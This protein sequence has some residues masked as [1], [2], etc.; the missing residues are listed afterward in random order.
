MTLS[1]DQK[2]RLLSRMGYAGP[3]GE[4][5]MKNFLQTNPTAAKKFLAF[6]K[7]AAT[8]ATP[9][10]AM[11][12]SPMQMAE[13]GSV[14]SQD[15]YKRR[16]D[17][18]YKAVTGEGI[19]SGGWNWYGGNL[20]SGKTTWDQVKS[21]VE[22]GLVTKK[23]ELDAAAQKR[24][25]NALS[26]RGIPFTPTAPVPVPTPVQTVPVPTPTR[27]AT[28]SQT[29]TKAD[30]TDFLKQEFGKYDNLNFD[31][32]AIDW[33]G[34]NLAEG[35]VTKE[36][37]A[38]NLAKDAATRAQEGSPTT[39]KSAA[40]YTD[41]LKQEFGKHP[42]LNFDQA[43]INWYGKNLAEGKVTEE[44]VK[45]NIAKDAATRAQEGY[46]ASPPAG[47]GD[48][49]SYGDF[50]KYHFDKYDNLNFDQ[51]AIDWY[52]QKLAEGKVTPEQVAANI[53]RD[54]ARRAQEGVIEDGPSTLSATELLTDFLG[55][56]P[57]DA[58]IAK[59]SGLIAN[60][61]TE[62][63]ISYYLRRDF[64]NPTDKSVLDN[65]D[66]ILGRPPNDGELDKY[67]EAMAGGMS[68]ADLQNLIIADY[69]I[70]DINAVFNKV[71]GREPTAA[72][73]AAF[74][75]SGAGLLDYEATLQG[76]VTAAQD[77]II[78][79]Y[80]A[81]FDRNPD[82]DGLE[83]YMSSFR[84]GTPLET[85]L[86]NI[87]KS[88]EGEAINYADFEREQLFSD[89]QRDMAQAAYSDP[90]A[91]VTT[92]DVAQMTETPG[93]II[94]PTT[95]QV[96]TAPQ[97]DP[98]LI[99]NTALATAPGS[100]GTATYG[101]AGTSGQVGE[102]L[103]GLQAAQGTLSPEAQAVAAQ[104]TLS[105]GAQATA[106]GFDPNRVQTAGTGP[107]AVTGDQLAT[108]AGGDAVAHAAQIAQSTGI[109]PVVAAQ[110]TVDP[111]Q[112]PT[113]A[114][115]KESEMAQAAIISS[116]GQLSPEA[117]AM[118]A[119][120]ESFN[121]DNGTLAAAAQGNVNA[122]DTVQG[123]LANLMQQFNDGTPQWAAGAM[124]AANSA[125][126]ARGLGGSS[127]ASAAIVQA[128]MESALPIAQ[129]DAQAFLQ[130]NLS[131]VDRRQQVALTNAAAQ[132]G[133][134]LQNLNNEQ[135]A[136]LQNSMNA[137]QLQSQDLSFMQQ[138]TIANAQIK[139]SLQGQNLNNRQQANI[140]TAA[141]YAEV[142]NINLNNRQQSALQNNSN[143]LNVE[144]ANLSNRQQAYIANAQLGGAL[145]NQVLSNQQQTAIVNAA[146]YSEAAN[147]TFNA[148]QQASLHNSTLM[149]TIGLAELGFEQATVLQNAATLAA[150]DM[151][152]LNNRQQAAVENAKGFLQVDL[153]NLNNEQT[154]SIFKSQQT[155]QALFTDQ[156]ADNA[157]KQFNASSQNQTDQ[158]FASLQESVSRFNATQVNA[159]NK[160][161]VDAENAAKQFNAQ[162]VDL[163]DRFNA[164]NSLVIAQ[165]NAQWRQNIATINTA[166]QNDANMEAAKTA[167]AFTGAA[168]EQ[169]WQRERD[170]MAFAFTSAESALDRELSILMADKQEGLARWQANEEDK[171]AK[172][173]LLTNIASK[174]LF[175]GA[176]SASG[177]GL[178]GGIFG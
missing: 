96:G 111:N 76:T 176:G 132:Q 65:F 103:G 90:T 156:A 100:T 175:G 61:L 1:T 108:A 163:R 164:Q 27:Q 88:K 112:L 172:G 53:A 41:F 89:A 85:I 131:N 106:T 81:I 142:A 6:D 137:F 113:P 67:A 160:S 94:D 75:S 73:I 171:A 2:H 148:E 21:N 130:M 36:Q 178:L 138:A 139:A 119:R 38:A 121:V 92:A 146:R 66:H 159:V 25:E 157:A 51:A 95:G 104:G 79:A 30:Y 141:R 50:L 153:T 125:M 62:Q 52:G 110:G 143:K 87:A 37:V 59:Y 48:A 162:M 154:T 114:Q 11:P 57:T 169:L 155:I 127:M 42:N 144:L 3:A 118:A 117:I 22:K 123:Q 80:R 78:Q 26:V 140:V 15:E 165:S 147:I 12:S 29:K 170:L 161:N 4:E 49:A 149:Q 128:A 24:Y 174:V 63:E 129:Q 126:S 23:A 134:A 107:M 31:Q 7:A 8:L 47:S 43:A 16:L 83:W 68:Y 133:L 168:L 152:N 116:G 177:S 20:A 56:A 18:M 158:F 166:A 167:N 28:S 64:P 77:Q 72:D 70:T 40:D 60:G 82:A 13:G 120:L 19:D 54:A 91:N 71:F 97:I 101:S 35:K 105:Q 135:Q 99:G 14:V 10:A 98:S 17:A 39:T 122:Q 124:R 102:A 44:Q 150:M 136:A 46:V 93:T 32:A 84:S 69:E 5:G 74:E 9:P 115:I 145:Q 151:T 109:D 58:Q 86:N 55:G 45:A 173:Y 33:Y 34:K